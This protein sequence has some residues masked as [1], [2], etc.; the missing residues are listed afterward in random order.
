M[1]E[2]RVEW[3]GVGEVGLE[4][5]VI[6]SSV[7]SQHRRQA[8]LW[9]IMRVGLPVVLR[10]LGRGGRDTGDGVDIAER[11]GGLRFRGRADAGLLARESWEG[12]GLGGRCVKGQ[13]RMLGIWSLALG[14]GRGGWG[15]REGGVEGGYS[16]K[17]KGEEGG[18]K[19][20]VFDATV[21]TLAHEIK[22]PLVAI[23][24]F[25]SLLPEKYGD[26]EFRGEFSRLVSMDV[27]RVNEVLENLLEY[28]FRSHGSVRSEGRWRALGQ[29]EE[30]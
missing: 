6:S 25:A 20:S 8:G 17:G 12:G 3:P 2:G 21:W 14:Y 9:G 7:R 27:K 18:D 23:S 1:G 22:N 19:G 30:L 29:G 24:T 13:G 28:E 4:V 26:E 10:P 11:A 15:V 5:R 16:L